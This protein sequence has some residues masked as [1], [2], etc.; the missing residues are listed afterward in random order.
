MSPIGLLF[1]YKIAKQ[2][3]KINLYLLLI[4]LFLNHSL[5]NW[6]ELNLHYKLNILT[7]LGGKFLLINQDSTVT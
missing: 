7:V 6:S 4:F 3:K 1:E 2:R 5:L